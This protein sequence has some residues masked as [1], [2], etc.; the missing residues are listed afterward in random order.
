MLD[1]LCALLA[2]ANQTGSGNAPDE[3]AAV[4]LWG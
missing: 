1:Q 3:I 2:T 4:N